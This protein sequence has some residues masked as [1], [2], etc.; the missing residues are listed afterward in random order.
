[1]APRPKRAVLS[2]SIPAIKI[3][4]IMA[5]LRKYRTLDMDAKSCHPS[6]Y[7]GCRI[8]SYGS[9]SHL[10]NGYKVVKF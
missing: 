9:R 10:A 8:N 2:I 7:E 6:S 4:E 5:G 1:M 3:I